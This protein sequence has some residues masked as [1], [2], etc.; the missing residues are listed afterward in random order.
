M[1]GCHSVAARSASR[2][3]R[4]RN[5]AS[6]VIAFGQD[7]ERVATRQP[8]MLGKVDL[9]HTAGPQRAQ[10]GV[11]GELR[12]GWRSRCPARRAARVP[13]H[14]DSGADLISGI[15]FNRLG[16]SQMRKRLHSHAAACLGSAWGGQPAGGRRPSA[17]WLFVDSSICRVT[18][19]L[20]PHPA[21]PTAPGRLLRRRPEPPTRAQI[22]SAG[23]TLSRRHPPVL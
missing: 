18:P 9:G 2:L 22:S 16:D 4:S 17:Q 19:S 7:F 13:R 15:R 11:A 3:N 1:C 5:S 12:R 21:R 6:A 10:D 20:V 23:Q 8:R 14:R